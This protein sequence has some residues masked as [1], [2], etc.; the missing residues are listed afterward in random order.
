MK[1]ISKKT[2]IELLK[3]AVMFFPSDA[4]NNKC[5]RVQSFVMLHRSEQ[6]KAENFGITAKDKEYY[7][8]RLGRTDITYPALFLFE[9]G[10]TVESNFNTLNKPKKECANFEITVIDQLLNE[11]CQNCSYCEKRSSYDLTSDTYN[12]LMQVLSYFDNVA[13]VTVTNNDL[14]TSIIWAHTRI[15]DAMVTAGEI[16]SYE[17]DKQSTQRFKKMLD[18]ENKNLSGNYYR[19]IT[20]QDLFGTFLQIRLCFKSCEPCDFGFDDVGY[21]DVISCCH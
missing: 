11:S 20:K 9:S 8:N 2:F 17:V 21:G 18:E 12:L 15:L 13:C 4:E 6:Y 7:F 19:H 14:S 10:V 5:S 16:G 3:Q 1:Y